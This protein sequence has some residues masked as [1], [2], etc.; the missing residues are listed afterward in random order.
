MRVTKI[1]YPNLIVKTKEKQEA[2]SARVKQVFTMVYRDTHG[3]VFFF[4]RQR[5]NTKRWGTYFF[6]NLKQ[7]KKMINLNN[8]LEIGLLMYRFILYA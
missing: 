1:N 7:N 6:T 5:C 8:K 4:L 2:R 3:Q